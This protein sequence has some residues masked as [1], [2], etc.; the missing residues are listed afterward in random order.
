[1][2]E[3]KNFEEQVND[4]VNQIG[5]S[6]KKG[7]D[8]LSSFVN[9]QAEILKM[10]SDISQAKKDLASAYEQFGRG[11]YAE[12]ILKTTFENKEFV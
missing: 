8:A 7:A 5:S 3:N 11:M 4:V 12:T 10:K 2:D 1:M 9:Q 6:L